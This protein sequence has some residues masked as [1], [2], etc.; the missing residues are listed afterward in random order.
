MDFKKQYNQYPNYCKKKHSIPE[1]YEFI[2]FPDFRTTDISWKDK[3]YSLARNGLDAG[4]GIIN[5][6]RYDKQVIFNI[7]QIFEKENQ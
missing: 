2:V 1:A 4:I 5:I 3:Y 6:S 7:P